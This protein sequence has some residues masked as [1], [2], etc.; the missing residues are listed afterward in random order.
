M[1]RCGC[2]LRVPSFARIQTP[3]FGG[4][5]FPIGS[6]F[7]V[8]GDST[9]LSQLHSLCSRS[10]RMNVWGVKVN[11]IGVELGLPDAVNAL[12]VMDDEQRVNCEQARDWL[13]ARLSEGRVPRPPR[14]HILP[15]HD[16]K[17][18]TLAAVER[19][20][21]ALSAAQLKVLAKECE[22]GTIE[23]PEFWISILPRMVAR[24]VNR[25]KLAGKLAKAIGIR[26]CDAGS[27]R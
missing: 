10:V 8:A 26:V 7:G 15:E 27:E 9:V 16:R 20:M 22:A 6:E 12:L 18:G 23:G 2:T 19:A 5:F 4:W 21:K 17:G 25:R 14:E 11:I 13:V 3:P 24:E 1:L